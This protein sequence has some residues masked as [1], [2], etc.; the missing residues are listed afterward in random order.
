MD[1]WIDVSFLL[2]IASALLG[3]VLT[4]YCRH[5][6][7]KI[8]ET[9]GGSYLS[10]TREIAKRRPIVGNLLLGLLSFLFL[11][12]IVFTLLRLFGSH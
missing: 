9:Q 8:A 7:Q 5:D 10:M 6:Y 2:F 1:N 3:L 4:I 12:A 11:F